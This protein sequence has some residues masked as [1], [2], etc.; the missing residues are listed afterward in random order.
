MALKQ[1]SLKSVTL[2]LISSLAIMHAA[3]AMA[4]DY[5]VMV[6]GDK[7]SA[8]MKQSLQAAGATINAELPEVGLLMV[9]SDND[10]FRSQAGKVNGVQSVMADIVM[11]TDPGQFYSSDAIGMAASPPNTG[12][13]DFLFDL[14]WGHTAVQAT[15][16]WEAGFRGTGVRVAVLD[17]G[18]DST[19]ADIA[20]NLNTALSASFVP[21]E[22]YNI[23]AGAHGTHVAGTIAAADNA[24][25]VIGVAP[26]AELV[27]VKVLSAISGSGSTSGI[28][29]GMVY[30]ANIDADIVNMSLGYS[31]GLPANCK[32][33]D[34]NGG[35]VQYPAKDCAD[36]FNAYNRVV[37]YMNKKGT[38][39]IASAGN[40]GRDTNHDASTRIIPGGVPGV[41]T[42]SA[43][44][45]YLWGADPNT[46]L[47]IRAH[48]SNY[49]TNSIDFSAPGGDY[50]VYYD[51]GL[52]P[53]N[54]PVVPGRPC[55]VYDMVL[56]SVP[57]GWSWYAGTS[58][59]APHASGVAAL[60]IGANGGDMKPGEVRKALARS[61]DDLGKP[62]KDADHGHGRVNA[63]QSVVK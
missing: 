50:D 13:D 53:C 30:A 45:P 61:A 8:K 23:P 37:D 10:D 49:G 25:G 47:D 34:G 40:D 16:A 19:H 31:G 36:I 6:K 62:G 26:E 39:V 29:Q 15:D 21:G 9:S 18:I 5:I 7:A 14:Q 63:Y 57:G 17:S 58:M 24:Y 33:D 12:D 42:V 51:Y 38:T 11:L 56:S 2:G 41:I 43:T 60:I 59:A 3:P 44:A 4:A 52:T 27:A 46:D 1:L 35:T 55:Y 48:Y 22:A 28:L 54:G 20:P 32:F